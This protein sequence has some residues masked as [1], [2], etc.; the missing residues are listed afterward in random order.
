MVRAVGVWLGVAGTVG[1]VVLG[2]AGAAGAAGCSASG[3][4]YAIDS[5]SPRPRLT[6][7]S[8][9]LK[10]DCLSVANTAAQFAN[11]EMW[12]KTN[13]PRVSFDTWVEIGMTSGTLQGGYRGL[14]WYWADKRPDNSY[15]EHYLGRARPGRAANVNVMYAGG[16]KWNVYLGRSYA[17]TSSGNGVNG[18]SVDTG[19]EVTTTR[20]TVNGSS[21]NYQY[22]NGGWHAVAPNVY[23]SANSKGLW[24]TYAKRGYFWTNTG[25]RRLG[26]AAEKPA[27]TAPVPNG[28]SAAAQALGQ[29]GR[30]AAANAGERIP[31]GLSYVRTTRQRAA[32]ATGS[33]VNSDESVYVVQMRGNFTAPRHPV[34][35]KSGRP[36]TGHAL[37]LVIDAATGQVTDWGL[38]SEMSGSFGPRTPI[39]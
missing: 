12:V 14:L 1:C 16:A 36:V 9:D 8:A 17:G 32:A 30:T 11:Y 2:G 5:A 38:T 34:P 18:L 13:T 6:A 25:C 20:T 33:R 21:S 23:R 3:H 24:S 10:V 37:T 35:G 26:A 29:I 19:A 15:Y 27:P 39:A 31:S 7:A 4:C 22:R 28:R